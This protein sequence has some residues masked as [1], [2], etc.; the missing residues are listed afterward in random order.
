M[1][2]K[3][4]YTDMKEKPD[5]VHTEAINQ[6]A[7]RKGNVEDARQAT[8]TEHSLTLVQAFKAY[9]KAVF[10]SM[11]VSTAIIMEGYDTILIGSFYGY[12][13]FQKKYGSFYPDI[14]YQLS[15]AWQIGLGNA[16][17]VGTVIG[18]F[19]NGWLTHRFGYR[20]VFLVSL[21]FLAMFIFIVFFAPSIQVLVVGEVLCGIPWGVFSTTGP[22]YAS[23][24]CPLALRGYLFIYVSLCW[25][26]G[27]FIA[28][29]VLD[30]L[31]SLTSE[32]S[33]R[34]PFAIQWIWPVPLFVG[35]FFAPESP[36]WLVRRGRLEDAERSVKRLA[37]SSTSIDPKQTVAMMVHTNNTEIEIQ[38]GTNYWDCFKGVDLRR[39]EI[40]CVIFAGQVLSGSSFAY[41]ATYFFEQAGMSAAN[42][43][44][45]NVGGTAVAFIA[46]ILSWFLMGNF[47]RRQI[48]LYGMIT[49]SI[50]LF[51][52]GCVALAPPS[53]QTAIWAQASLAIVWLFVYASTV[54]PLAYTIVPETSATRLRSK[55]VCLAR[56]AYNIVNVI[57]GVLEPYMINPT[58]WNWKGKT[59]FFWFGTSFL[60]ACWVFFRLPETR[61]RTYEE[62]DILFAKR[63]NARKFKDHI[64]D[65]YGE[66]DETMKID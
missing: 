28:A 11:L 19:A 47:G 7:L 46:T 40:V 55:S 29:G 36:W 54:G 41:S 66:H 27:Q 65:A 43:Y 37:S 30:G 26:I 1:T 31:E 24:V 17:N 22:A 5:V 12:P 35:M 63:V 33:Y 18:V 50:I 2:T 3:S 42:A 14:G 6:D 44:K 15:A 52:I 9:P 48:Y 53:N 10:W 62:L 34:I 32:W 64:I 60:T 56:N 8:A 51:I 20:R 57:A 13:T 25:T 23:E 58:E 4:S 61:G 45:V 16:A 49:E 21:F 59:A 39:T 38:S